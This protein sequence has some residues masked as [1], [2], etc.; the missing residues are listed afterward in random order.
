ML[1]PVFMAR[2]PHA[3]VAKTA[4]CRLQWVA[5]VG[6]C[7]AGQSLLYVTQD[8]TGEGGGSRTVMLPGDEEMGESMPAAE[9]TELDEPGHREVCTIDSVALQIQS[10]LAKM[11]FACLLTMRVPSPTCI[12]MLLV[13]LGPTAVIL[14]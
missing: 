4:R 11:S 14:I 3:Y 8:A 2:I 6:N 10:I 9:A 7:S 1:D 5:E 12:R 13:R